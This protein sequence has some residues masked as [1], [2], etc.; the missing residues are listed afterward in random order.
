[1]TVMIWGGISHGQNTDRVFNLNVDVTRACVSDSEK[2]LCTVDDSKG[3]VYVWDFK[4]R[5][6]LQKINLDQ[7][8]V[9]ALMVAMNQIAISKDDEYVVITNV[10]SNGRQKLS[11]IYLIDI[12]NGDVKWKNR[13]S[14]DVRDV[15]LIDQDRKIA[16]RTIGD[17]VQII[18]LEDGEILFKHNDVDNEYVL[19]MTYDRRLNVL[20]VGYRPQLVS[21]RNEKVIDIQP[22]RSGGFAYC[23]MHYDHEQALYSLVGMNG[24]VIT[25]SE[26]QG[27]PIMKRNKYPKEKQFHGCFE[28][29]SSHRKNLIIIIG[30]PNLPDEKGFEKAFGE[31]AIYDRERQATTIKRQINEDV[32]LYGKRLKAPSKY[33]FVTL[34]GR[35]EIVTLGEKSN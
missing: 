29:L 17:G 9:Y 21:I 16:A 6:I 22:V 15:L 3:I 20:Q 13:Y 12:K 2:I 31:I 8:R 18:S 14:I 24:D 34:R 7:P 32:Y 5:R 28:V 10:I 35:V 11:D 27:E 1:M 25:L 19:S 23:Y 26:Q 30:R 4:T 33:A